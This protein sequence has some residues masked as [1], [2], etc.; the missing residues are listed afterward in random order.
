MTPSLLLPLAQA[1][2]LRSGGHRVGALAALSRHGFARHESTHVV[3]V[4]VAELRRPIERR[5]VNVALVL[6]PP[7]DAAR[8]AEDRHL[9]AVCLVAHAVAVGSRVLRPELDRARDLVP[10][11]PQVDDDVLLHVGVDRAYR[12]TSARERGERLVDRPRAIV[13]AYLRDEERKARRSAVASAA[14]TASG[15]ARD[16]ASR[17]TRGGRCPTGVP[18]RASRCRSS[19]RRCAARAPPRAASSCG[20]L[21]SQ[22]GNR[23]SQMSSHRVAGGLPAGNSA[24]MSAI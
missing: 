6:G 14:P 16:V 13:V 1:Q 12:V 4:E 19:A 17:S 18:A 20:A 5:L 9:V 7:G 2:G 23:T 22:A 3:D 11:T 24:A 15:A 21:L 8:A 10:T